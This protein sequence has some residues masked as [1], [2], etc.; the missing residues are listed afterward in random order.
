MFEETG[1]PYYKVIAIE[2]RLISTIAIDKSYKVLVQKEAKSIADQ[3][4]VR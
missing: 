3:Y 4:T 2:C 1:N